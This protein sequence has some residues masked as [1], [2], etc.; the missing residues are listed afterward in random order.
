MIQLDID[1]DGNVSRSTS[2][3]ANTDIACVSKFHE[4]QSLASIHP[5]MDGRL[6]GAAQLEELTKSSPIILYT[7][8]VS[9]DR[10]EKLAVVEITAAEDGLGYRY[11]AIDVTSL[12]LAVGKLLAQA[13]VQAQKDR[14]QIELL[15][16]EVAELKNLAMTDSL[17]G[18]ANRRAFLARLQNEFLRARR[19]GTTLSLLILDVDCFK[20]YN[21]NFGHPA[22]DAVLRAIADKIGSTCRQTDFAARIG[23]DEFAVVLSQT[24][25]PGAEIAS[26]RLLAEITACKLPYGALSATLGI[27]S[28]THDIESIDALIE[29]A[30]K[31]LYR[32]KS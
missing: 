16:I 5:D 29:I 12:P 15:K 32:N 25:R 2:D 8:V 10:C 28:Y 6:F 13:E 26:C 7:R 27:A 9:A 14:S 24:D 22:G 23:G 21:D 11:T 31:D 19:Y 30:D 17:T 20:S 3:A 18:L 1:L 4:G